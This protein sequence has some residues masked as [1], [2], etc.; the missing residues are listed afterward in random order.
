MEERKR[1]IT[2]KYLRER[3]VLAQSEWMVPEAYADDEAVLNSE[4][5]LEPEVDLQRQE[6]GMAPPRPPQR[7][8]MPQ[9]QNSNWLL[10]VDPLQDDPYASFLAPAKKTEEKPQ[11]DWSAWGNNQKASPSA[12]AQSDSLFY[13]RDAADEQPSSTFDLMRQGKFNPQDSRAF[14]AEGMPQ[15]FP[16]NP[17]LGSPY[18]SYQS[19]IQNPYS[20]S[21]L[22][23]SRDRAYNS[24]QNSGRLRS[25]YSLN[26]QADE[27]GK[28]GSGAQQR[29]GG[30]TPYKSPYQ[31]Q[32]EQRQQQGGGYRKP[33]TEF[34]RQDPYQKWKE[35]NSNRLDPTRDDAFIDELMPKARR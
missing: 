16:Q 12:G 9:A 19:G 21:G 33:E 31:I 34:R 3:T 27:N 18:Q 29:K 10:D 24:P 35:Q 13:Q 25:P 4:K 15:G 22:D 5:F 17:A 23:L 26:S 2:R 7:R 1:R 6:P 20:A 11:A 28:F 30:D 14:S 8:P 32:R